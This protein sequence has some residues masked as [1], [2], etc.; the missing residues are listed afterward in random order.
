M[1]RK[2]KTT[3]GGWVFIAGVAFI[4]AAAVLYGISEYTEDT[5]KGRVQE[6]VSIGLFGIGLLGVIV[7]PNIGQ[8]ND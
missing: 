8:T 1:E 2:K 7:G 6:Y 5:T 3:V 4:V